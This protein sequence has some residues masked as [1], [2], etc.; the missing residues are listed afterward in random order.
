MYKRQAKT[1]VLYYPINP[2]HEAASWARF[3]AEALPRFLAGTYAGDYQAALIAM[4][5]IHI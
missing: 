1:G 4:S 2:G 5:L 3:T